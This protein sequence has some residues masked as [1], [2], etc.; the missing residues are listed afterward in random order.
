[1]VELIR[2]NSKQDP[3]VHLHYHSTHSLLD[4]FGTEDETMQEVARLGQPAIAFTDH[5]KLTGIYSGYEAAKKN[6]LKFIA[7]LEAYFVPS[8]IQANK[9]EP[10]Y[11]GD[12]GQ[13]D[14]SG[15][16]AYTHLTMLAENNEGL[17][18]LF[19]LNLQA[20]QEGFYKKPRISLEMLS[21]RPKGIIVTT[22]CPSGEV[23]TRLRL[24]QYT[25][26]REFAAHL[27]DIV[28]HDN[29]YVEL[30]DHGMRSNLER[31][32]RQGLLR[33]ARELRL[34][35]VATNDCHYV[36]QD[37][38]EA[39]EEL[40]AINTKSVMSELPDYAG[41]NR[42]AFE[43]NEYYIK[44][45]Q[46]MLKLFPEK[47]FTG[48][49]SNTLAIA[50]RCDIKID[51]R[52]DLRP[53]F[54]IPDGYA[55]EYEYLEEKAFNGLKERL[56]EKAET[57]QY[58]DQL[59]LELNV[60][61]LK[62]YSN[63]FLVVADFIQWAKDN[64]IAVGPG[65]GSAGGSLLAYAMHITDIDPIR[66]GLFF[67]RF[68]NP[69]RDSPPDIDCDFD[70]RYRD[71]VYEYVSHKYGYDHVSQVLTLGRI[72]GKNGL[73]DVARIFE[74]PFSVSNDLTKAYPGDV[75]GKSM[76]LHDV[77]DESSARYDDGADLRAK[78]VELN[79]ER[80]A[81]EALK[82]EGRVRSNGVHACAVLISGKPLTDVVPL[83]V[84]Q[85][86]NM[87]VAQWEYPVCEGL[88][89][90]KVD[91][92]GLRNLGVMQDA[93]NLIEKRQGVRVDLEKIKREEMN[94]PATFKLLSEGNTL[95]VFQLDGGPM[96]EL[97]MKMK[98]TTFEDISAVIALY[99]PG[100]MGV[101]AHNDYADRKN[102]L[103]EVD[104]IH[105]EFSEVLK[106]ILEETYGL[107]TYQEQIMKIAQV[108]AGYSLGEADLLRRAMGKKKRYIL[109]EQ[110]SHFQAGAKERG[111][112]DEAIKTLWDTIV[113][114]ADYAFNKSHSV[115][116]A[117]I[118]Y[119]TAFL[120]A[121]YM[122]EYMSALL[123][124]VSDDKDKT[125]L[126]L[127]DVRKNGIQVLPPD[128]NKSLAGYAPLD[129]SHIL[130]GLKALKGVSDSVSGALVEERETS[131]AYADMS[132]LLNRLPSNVINRRVL[133]AFG[134]GGAFD[135][136]GY[137]RKSVLYSLDGILETY[138]KNNRAKK[139]QE[140]M[141]V[142]LFD[143]FDFGEELKPV[144]EVKDF[145]EFSNL[146][147][148]KH[149]REVLG[150]YI[151]GHP[152][153]GLKIENI[154]H[155]PLESVVNGK[156]P[157]ATGFVRRGEEPIVTVVGL[158]S[159]FAAR[160]SRKGN[161]FGLGTI[162]DERYSLE[163]VMFGNSFTEYGSV[164]KPDLVCAL[165]GYPQKR[166]GSEKISFVVQSV[167]PLE[168]TQNGSLPVRVKVTRGQWQAGESELRR[169]LNRH[170]NPDGTDVV[171][172]I[173]EYGGSITEMTIPMNVEGSPLLIAEIRNLFGVTCIGRWRV[174]KSKEIQ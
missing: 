134:Y 117:Y 25:E 64:N 172:S 98:P 16:G 29:V 44:S 113:P 27:V 174:P 100:P 57:Q 18:N 164:V 58:R 10:T 71:R 96:R 15:R 157:F 56:P 1:M 135:S 84:R 146:D 36:T 140:K 17:K 156:V 104:Y 144:Y 9:K 116:Y 63:Y 138:Q 92:L 142:S 38:C 148:L 81:G 128:V 30:M 165:T 94:D 21:Q 151:S 20:S 66:H 107:I 162:E 69:Q 112:S 80:V 22:G 147:K 2:T 99:R 39:H 13:G 83:E 152:L 88:G 127:D 60:I 89:L 14:V 46:E 121:N 95:G 149:E 125:A 167:K 62:D 52:D 35:L 160:M 114:F 155:V 170:S 85:A 158:V 53:K 41:G 7:G 101:N 23:Q 33:I 122:A 159:L 55:T 3:F 90:L 161:H 51:Y 45:S 115:G 130:F 129:A 65:R 93:L 50:E 5:G 47:E 171:I 169:I 74:F 82:M 119:M 136:L 75:F 103:Q 49:V 109:D 137:T 40:L 168:F 91:F 154:A 67:E 139:K 97:L 87:L 143:G 173:K 54:P 102:G 12:G 19:A 8:T 43:G 37:Q 133:E 78:V 132:D 106:P 166:E 24:G 34:P 68:L 72:K 4:G 150:F 108:V 73:K 70:D 163:F 59:K 6:G 48:A 118:A 11:F 86:D 105:P 131:G 110:Y 126:Y 145:A 141:G 28:G 77:Y 124:S 123:T 79:A 26:A 76:S 153:D 31:G 61:K 42:F 111:Y 32:V 120:K